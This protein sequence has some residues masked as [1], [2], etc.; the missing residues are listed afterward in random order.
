MK[1]EISYK[2]TS[3]AFGVLILCSV[4]A[5]YA[6]AWEEPTEAPPGGNVPVP[7]NVGDVTQYKEGALGIGGLFQTD[8]ETHLAISGGNVG[9]GTTSPERPLHILG[10]CPGT[11]PAVI[12]EEYTDVVGNGPDVF[13]LRARGTAASPQNV[14]VGD[15]IGGLHFGSRGY[16]DAKDVYLRDTGKWASE[17]GG[18]G[19]GIP[20]K[21]RPGGGGTMAEDTWYQADADGFVMAS[22]SGSH[23]YGTIRIWMNSTQSKA[24]AVEMLQQS[25]YSD[26]GVI[27]PVPSGWYFRVEMSRNPDGIY[28][29]LPIWWIPFSS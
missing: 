25:V 1:K 7:I 14:A 10:E 5:F 24:G 21:T 12:V 15:S 6:I 13:F 8:N 22:G 26:G 16:L 11:C 29:P 9:I 18:G 19:F 23:D 28:N 2:I 27:L 3:I 4:I 20:T 17:G